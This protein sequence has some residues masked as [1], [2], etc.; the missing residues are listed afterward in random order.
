M[1]VV[2]IKVRRWQISN[3]ASRVLRTGGD[4][5]EAGFVKVGREGE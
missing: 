5:D 2:D 4:E 1:L 3:A